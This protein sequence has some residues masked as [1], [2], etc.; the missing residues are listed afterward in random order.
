M[1]ELS[2]R[3]IVVV[4]ACLACLASTS[5]DDG[6]GGTQMPG[7]SCGEELRCVEGSI[8]YNG[9]CVGNGALRFTLSWD[10]DSDFDLH[11]MTPDGSQIFWS[12]PSAQGGVLDVDQCASSCSVGQ[13]VENVVFADDAPGGHYQYW[14]EN[15]NGRSA[16]PFTIVVETPDAQVAPLTGTL[17][18]TAGAISVTGVLDL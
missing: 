2:I 14:V 15:F 6:G 10:V 7:Q 12:S 3:A 9:T 1:G 5:A 16:G 11:V 13:H 18:A 4:L 8:C 17:P